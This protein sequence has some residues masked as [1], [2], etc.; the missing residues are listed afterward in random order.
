MSSYPSRTDRFPAFPAAALMMSGRRETCTRVRCGEEGMHSSPPP[1]M[2]GTMIS[3]PT[4]IISFLLIY[5]PVLHN[6][7]ASFSCVAVSE[8][9]STR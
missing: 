3:P 2:M 6:F 4:S 7:L 8:N 5:D 1:S 9:N